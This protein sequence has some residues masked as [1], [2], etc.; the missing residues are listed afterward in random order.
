MSAIEKLKVLRGGNTI[1]VGDVSFGL[2]RLVD[3][4]FEEAKT[5]GPE[6]P[7]FHMP[8]WF[9]SE[10]PYSEQIIALAKRHNIEPVPIPD[11]FLPEYV[12]KLGYVWRRVDPK[13]IDHYGVRDIYEREMKCL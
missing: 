7:G 3:G 10:S 12:P 9:Y 6:N 4:A 1:V 2:S 5:Y 11:G 13:W 8:E